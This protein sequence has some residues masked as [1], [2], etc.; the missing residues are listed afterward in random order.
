MIFQE[1]LYKGTAIRHSDKKYYRPDTRHY[2]TTQNRQN[3]MMW[4][5]YS[6][7]DICI[8]YVVCTIISS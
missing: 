6:I 4:Y 1:P 2:T 3:F 5:L 7:S 8:E